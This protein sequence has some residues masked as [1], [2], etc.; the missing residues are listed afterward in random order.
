LKKPELESPRS[1]EGVPREADMNL[2][3][4]KF[5]GRVVDHVDV[6]DEDT[7]RKVGYIQSEGVGFE[8]IG[9]ISISLFGGKYSARVNRYDECKGFVRGVETV[10]IK[11]AELLSLPEKRAASEAA[12]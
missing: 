9:G 11:A 8:K 1:L 4:K 12:E 6:I 7:G 3:F 10:L 2:T 5:D